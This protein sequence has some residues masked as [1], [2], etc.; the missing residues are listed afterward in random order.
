MYR[1]TAVDRS[2]AQTWI[3]LDRTPL[4][5]RGIVQAVSEQAITLNASLLFCD[6]LPGTLL[7]VG[8]LSSRVTEATRKG[9]VTVEA[10]IAETETVRQ[11]SEARIWQIAVG[12]SVEVAG[13]THVSKAGIN[14]P[15]SD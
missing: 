1:I 11:G 7:T 9:V 2:A 4:L 10:E 12:D 5:A 14:R 3:T 13:M 8:E 6:R 15:V